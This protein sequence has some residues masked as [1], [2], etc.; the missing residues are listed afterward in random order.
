MNTLHLEII[1]PEKIVYT[2][3]VGMVVVPGSEGNLGILPNHIPLFTK[4]KSG[5][6]KVK[7]E[8]EVILL[9]VSGGFVDVQPT[10]VTI[11]ADSA[12][13][14][15]EIDEEKALAAKTRAEELMKQKLS[16]KESTLA[17]ASLRRA[18]AELRVAKRHKSRGG[19]LGEQNLS[20]S[21]E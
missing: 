2:D 20:G 4:L 19:G 3:E 9:A 8:N 5:E 10:K 15:E 17:E 7:K 21:R 12:I 18:L 6:I 1:T 11:L 16:E 14:S 13:R